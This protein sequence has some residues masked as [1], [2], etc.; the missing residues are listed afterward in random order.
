MTSSASRAV[1]GVCRHIS[2]GD[3]RSILKPNRSRRVAIRRM[4]VASSVVGLAGCDSVES[5][6]VVTRLLVAERRGFLCPRVT[7]D[8]QSEPALTRGYC[9]SPASR[10][11]GMR[12]DTGAL[13]CGAFW[14]SSREA[15]AVDGSERGSAESACGLPG[16]LIPSHSPPPIRGGR[17][18]GKCAPEALASW[19]VPG[20]HWEVCSRSSLW[21][22]SGPP[23][24]LLI[25]KTIPDLIRAPD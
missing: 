12:D 18:P 8:S 24:S 11:E 4:S 10:L 25:Q 3:E 2:A 9:L 7:L 19:C 21:C 20:S 23:Y 13:H 6:D 15:F 22:G 1:P 14:G 17:E 5:S 16:P